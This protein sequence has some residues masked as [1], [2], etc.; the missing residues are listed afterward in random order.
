MNPAAPFRPAFTR[1]LVATLAIAPWPHVQSSEAQTIINAHVSTGGVQGNAA[2]DI[3]GHAAISDDG[4]YVAFVSYATNL[5]A[6]D[7][8][9]FADVFVH[10]N[11]TGVTVLISLDTAGGPANE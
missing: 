5:V 7:T 3:N 11:L 8:N 6:G 1:I 4:V 10:N 9:G 2:A